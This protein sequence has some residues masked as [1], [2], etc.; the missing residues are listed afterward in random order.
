MKTLKPHARSAAIAGGF[1]A[2][3]LFTSACS[4]SS[5]GSDSGDGGGG[6]GSSSGKGKGKQSDQALKHRKCLRENGLDV[7]DPKPGQDNRGIAINGDGMSK[8]KMEKAMKACR[9][10]APGGGGKITQA[11]K[12]K[13]LK[14][15]R[16]MRKN[17]VDMPDPEFSGGGGSVKARPMP[18]GAAQKKFEKANKACESVTR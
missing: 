9:S 18:K 6:G 4:G 14:F 10:K 3:A 11:D 12:D 2:L 1:V 13:A 16:C 5:G 8:E 17:G 15:A 7:P